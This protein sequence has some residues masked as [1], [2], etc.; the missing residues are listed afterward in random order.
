MWPYWGRYW[1]SRLDS[2]IPEM[3]AHQPPRDHWLRRLPRTHYWLCRVRPTY[4]LWQTPEEQ[5]S[6]LEG[7]QYDRV[8]QVHLMR[9]M[10]TRPPPL[11]TS[12]FDAR[13]D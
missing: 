7:V 5:L 6:R 1:L 12:A 8:A 11:P 9:R 4:Y 2:A 3:S 10:N 13:R